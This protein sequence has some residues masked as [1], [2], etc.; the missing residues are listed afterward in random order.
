MDL[1]SSAFK[2]ASIPPQHYDHWEKIFSDFIND[3]TNLT[4][5]WKLLC[6]NEFPITLSFFAA[7]NFAHDDRV[8]S[9]ILKY[10]F[11]KSSSVYLTLNGFAYEP[12]H[13]DFKG[14]VNYIRS[15]LKDKS[16][17]YCISWKHRDEKY[18]GHTIFG[19]DKRRD[20]HIH[21]AENGWLAPLYQFMRLVDLETM[22][23]EPIEYE[24]PDEVA[25]LE[26]IYIQQIS[27]NY[28]L[29]NVVYNRIVPSNTTK[30]IHQTILRPQ[31]VKFVENALMSQPS[32]T[33]LGRLSV[34]DRLA[35][36][37]TMNMTT[38]TFLDTN[39]VAKFC[40]NVES[41]LMVYYRLSFWHSMRHEDD[42]DEEVTHE[43][44]MQ[45]TEQ[46]SQTSIYHHLHLNKIKCRP[47]NDSIEVIYGVFNNFIV[48]EYKPC[49]W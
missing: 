43:M 7:G 22:S 3:S 4:T 25:K 29:L 30:Y 5:I 37:A 27:K 48:P 26:E 38:L 24:H 8:R 15:M 11:I 12:N 16:L 9:Q 13:V 6:D 46:C 21:S 28:P 39:Q 18:V 17:V 1:F 33:Y 42:D 2:C 49:S 20:E 40:Q 23:V 45:R 19:I 10:A 36:P 41:D 34:G 35:D 31:F 14:L 32:A 44:E 47:Q